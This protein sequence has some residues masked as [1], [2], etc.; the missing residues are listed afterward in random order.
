MFL[1]AGR[2]LTIPFPPGRP[3]V[4]APL[5][6]RIIAAFILPPLL[7]F[8]ILK[9]PYVCFIPFKFVIFVITIIYY[10]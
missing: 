2:F 8:A 6:A 9:S 7:I 5:L 1:P 10:A 4:V 3:P